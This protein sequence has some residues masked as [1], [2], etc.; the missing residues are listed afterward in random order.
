MKI[1]KVNTK[2]KFKKLLKSAVREVLQE[3]DFL[4]DESNTISDII[5]IDIAVKI[6]GLAKS[7]IYLKT[8]KKEIPHHKKGR[9]LYFKRSELINWIEEGKQI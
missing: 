1:S 3:L 8:S 6:V 9:K 4:R 5:D 7:T 2:S